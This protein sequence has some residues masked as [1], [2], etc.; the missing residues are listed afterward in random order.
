[1]ARSRV[2]HGI[3]MGKRLVL[4]LCF[5][6][7]HVDQFILSAKRKRAQSTITDAGGQEEGLANRYTTSQAC[8]N[9]IQRNTRS[10]HSI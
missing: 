2:A 9:T 7:A 6:H 4:L 8:I 5:T 10:I 3:I 1:M